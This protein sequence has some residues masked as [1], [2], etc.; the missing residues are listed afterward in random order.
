MTFFL[1]D[2]ISFC[3]CE[4]KIEYFLS[5]KES[6]DKMIH[7]CKTKQ[8]KALYMCISVKFSRSVVPNSLWPHGLKHTSLPCPSPTPRACSNSCPSSRWCHP[9]ILSSVVPFSSHLQSFPSSGS[10]PTSRFFASGSQSI[11]ASASVSVLPVNNQDWF[12]LGLT[13]CISLQSKGLSRV[14]SNTTVWKHRY[15]GAQTSLWS[16]S[17]IHT[18]L[19]GTP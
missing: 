4:G 17:Y 14:F 6:E 8:T 5:M 1:R 18:R 2:Q 9:T 19:L 16:N 12:S 10:F 11:E 3:Y 7:F 13:G 15:F